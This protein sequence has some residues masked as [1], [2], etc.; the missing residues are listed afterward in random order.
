MAGGRQ[1]ALRLN[2]CGVCAA[3]GFEM[4]RSRYLGVICLGIGLLFVPAV[5][6]AQAQ[7]IAQAAVQRQ[8]E[9]QASVKRGAA[10]FAA[11]CTGYCHGPVG[12]AGSSAPALA[13]RGFDGDYIVKTVMYG[14][15]GTAMVGWGQRIP[16]DDSAAVI[17]YVKSLNGIVSAERLAAPPVLTPKAQ[18]G[19]DLFFDT[20]GELTRCSDCHQVSGLG[21]AVTQP[22]ANIPSDVS[23][24][25]NLST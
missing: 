2:P 16:K 6:S 25:R 22:I 17:A 13:N 15:A 12:T 5:T 11:T 7:V 1:M 8:S 19:H 3:R 9:Q 14:I 21:I 20:D 10:V 24:L 23:G 18:R 4:T